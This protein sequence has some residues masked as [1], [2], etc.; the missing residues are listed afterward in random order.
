MDQLVK[1]KKIIYMD[2]VNQI[3]WFIEKIQI[4]PIGPIL[5]QLIETDSVN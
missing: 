3:N 5:K 4:G 1:K 2:S